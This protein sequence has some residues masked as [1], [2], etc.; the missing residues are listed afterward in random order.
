MTI[1]LQAAANGSPCLRKLSLM[2]ASYSREEVNELAQRSRR[3]MVEGCIA[4]K[5]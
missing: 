3:L 4:K 2:F 1:V 5:K